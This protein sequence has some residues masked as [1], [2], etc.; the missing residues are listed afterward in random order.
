MKAYFV[1]FDK[2]KDAPFKKDKEYAGAGVITIFCSYF[3]H[4]IYLK[5]TPGLRYLQ[6]EGER[7]SGG[8]QGEESRSPGK[9]FVYF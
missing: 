1:H 6:E 4:E 7:L 8:S 2:K 9:Y 3:E 5:D